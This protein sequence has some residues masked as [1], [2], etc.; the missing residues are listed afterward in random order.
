MHII[1][2]ILVREYLGMTKG[3]PILVLGVG[4]QPAV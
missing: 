4:V 1:L 2:G 3:L